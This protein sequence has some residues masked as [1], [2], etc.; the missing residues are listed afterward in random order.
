MGWPAYLLQGIPIAGWNALAVCRMAGQSDRQWKSVLS[1]MLGVAATR[2]VVEKEG[3]RWV[4]PAS[5]FYANAAIQVD[6]TGWHPLYLPS[7]LRVSQCAHSSSRLR[8]DYIAIRQAV[9][10]LATVEWALVEA[11]GTKRNLRNI[12]S[13]PSSWLNQVRS[14][15]IDVSGKSQQVQ[16][17]LVVAARINPNGK[18]D[19]TRCIQLRA[20]NQH[21]GVDASRLPLPGAVEVA[22]ATLYGLFRAIRLPGVAGGIAQVARRRHQEQA[23]HVSEG[24]RSSIDRAVERIDE[25]LRD[26]LR[27]TWQTEFGE[28]ELQLSPDLLSFV[29][30]LLSAH[31]AADAVSALQETDERLTA[32]EKARR[33][34]ATA[35]G[36]VSLSMG[37]TFL[38]PERFRAT[39]WEPI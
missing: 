6:V 24:E 28:F 2:H 5:A 29:R 35:H 13:C 8:P 11:K 17:H 9:R 36:A 14:V 20:W 37:A 31:T 21:N 32:S 19:K 39:G 34:Q 30:R 25:G 4:A 16:R 12:A 26:G 23:L 3:Y 27:C 22:E 15:Q 38:V 7:V 18:R 33:E 1:W 10:G